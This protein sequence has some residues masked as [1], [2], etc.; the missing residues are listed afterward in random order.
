VPL[1]NGTQTFFSWTAPNDGKIHGLQVHAAK[2]VVTTEVGGAVQLSY[3]I[4]GVAKTL[5]IF[6]G[7]AA[8]P[9]VI[10]TT[11]AAITVDPG[12]T[13]TLQQNTALTG[14]QSSLLAA[15]VGAV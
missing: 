1:V 3:T 13:V 5:N 2:N 7:G 4:G 12:T 8:G 11:L 15:I 10:T 6:G 9:A 14:G